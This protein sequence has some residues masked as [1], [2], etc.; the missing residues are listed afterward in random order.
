MRGNV[1]LTNCVLAGNE[2]SK[3]LGGG[4]G[5][6]GAVCVGLVGLTQPSLE[7]INCLTDSNVQGNPLDLF[8]QSAAISSNESAV[9]SVRIINTIFTSETLAISGY[10]SSTWIS[11]ENSLFWQNRFYPRAENINTSSCL[12]GY[13]PIFIGPTTGTISGSP[14]FMAKQTTFNVTGLTLTVGALVGKN[15]N[16]NKLQARHALV[17]ANTANSIT[18]ATDWTGRIASGNTVVIPNYD[19]RNQ[20][21]GAVDTGIWATGVPSTDILGRERPVIYKYDIG[22]YEFQYTGFPRSTAVGTEWMLY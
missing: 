3:A 18:I 1:R 13:N 4:A 22:P 8:S 11:T 10:Y 21:S 5:I 15:I 7:L 20:Y 16:P 6:G 14:T 9:G 2:C 12:Q 19:L 17:L